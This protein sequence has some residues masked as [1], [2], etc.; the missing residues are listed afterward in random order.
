MWPN[1]SSSV[2]QIRPVEGMGGEGG[3]VGKFTV[4]LQV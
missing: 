4:S 2:Y 3:R 1:I